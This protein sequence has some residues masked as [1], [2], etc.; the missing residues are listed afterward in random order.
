MFSLSEFEV[1]T[2]R[3][4]DEALDAMASVS[5]PVPLAGG[6]DLMVQFE[7]RQLEPCTFVNIQDVPELHSLNVAIHAM[8]TYRDIRVGPVKHEYPML[9]L[10]AREVGGLAIQ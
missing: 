1:I 7:M 8:T 6:T 5:R 9:A 4:L 10:A 2:P 3:S